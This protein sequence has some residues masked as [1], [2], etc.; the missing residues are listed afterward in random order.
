VSVPRM[1]AGA[2][3]VR[4]GRCQ[5]ARRAPRALQRSV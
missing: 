4:Q 5:A 3:I 2:G 1:M